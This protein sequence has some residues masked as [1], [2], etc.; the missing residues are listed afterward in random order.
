MRYLLLDERSL[1]QKAEGMQNLAA[2]V[3]RLEFSAK[4]ADMRRVLQELAIWVEVS[5]PSSLQRSLYRFAVKWLRKHSPDSYPDEMDNLEGSMTMLA[6]RV[7]QWEKDIHQDGLK[8]GIKE[9]RQEGREIGRSDALLL[10]LD[11]R[12]GPVSEEH[13]AL[14]AQASA[15]QLNA[16]LIKT[17]NSKTVAE[18]FDDS[19]EP[20]S[21]NSRDL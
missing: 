9:G 13:H 4:P 10:L 12:F 3:F 14:I 20:S 15:E 19:D 1:L 16:W 18:I 2:A 17:L 8:A 21:N 11:N 5:A 7:E 6:Q